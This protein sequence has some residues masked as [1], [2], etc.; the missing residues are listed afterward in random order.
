[1][2]TGR[3][4]FLAAL[5]SVAACATV[6]AQG[7]IVVG[8]VMDTA[9]RPLDGAQVTAIRIRRTATA[10][11]AGRF[12]FAGLAKGREVFQVRR[13]GYQPQLFD[14]DLQ[15]DDNLRIGIT[16]A[17]DSVQRLPDVGV[18][19]P[20]PLSRGELLEQDAIGRVLASG[21][22]TSALIT[23]KELEK[24]SS[25]RL[26]LLLVKHGLKSRMY[27]WGHD[28][29]QC[30]RDPG[31]PDVY[32]DGVRMDDEFDATALLAP[33]LELV[34]VY[35]SKMIRPTQYSTSRRSCLVLI[36]TRR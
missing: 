32:V 19:A 28:R 22:P 21:A 5:L 17:R 33:D 34:E 36:W 27:T 31:G 10:D 7:A 25:D 35:R 3:T 29:L 30:P 6:M 2:V 9:G 8:V 24:A 15:P 4:P 14:L 26:H 13:I 1:V 16:L 11:A 18:V 23:R 20:K 12:M